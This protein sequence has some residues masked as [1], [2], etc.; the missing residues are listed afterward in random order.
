[1]TTMSSVPCSSVAPFSPP[2]RTSAD[3]PQWQPNACLGPHRFRAAAGL[4]GGGMC[5]RRFTAAHPVATTLC[6]RLPAS[7]PQT[8]TRMRSAWAASGLLSASLSA[9]S[10][11]D[12]VRSRVDTREA[13]NVE[14]S[15][16]SKCGVARA[17]ACTSSCHAVGASLR[18]SGGDEPVRNFVYE[19]Y[20]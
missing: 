19:A 2:R 6:A 16:G 7:A 1:M 12:G 20:H 14:F 15:D 11:M 17:V 8:S 9:A 13:T 5:V 18:S 3:K 10:R 4:R